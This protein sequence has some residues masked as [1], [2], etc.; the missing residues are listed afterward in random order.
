MSEITTVAR[1][2]AKALFEHA[3]ANQT[4][5]AWSSILGALAKLV[6]STEINEF[7]RNPTAS[8]EQKVELLLSLLP[9]GMKQAGGA[10]VVN[11]FIHLLSMNKRL[12][13]LT[14]I[15]YQYEMLRAEQEKM[16]TAEVKAFSPLSDSQQEALIQSLTERL[17]RKVSLI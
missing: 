7:L 4:L 14:D 15:F 11:H 2:Y 9:D 17:Q 10:D 16:V 6:S 13:I 1:P 8:T 3:L 12:L 5:M